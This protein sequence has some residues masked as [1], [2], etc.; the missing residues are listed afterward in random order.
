MRSGVVALV[1][2]PNSGK[3]TLF[4]WLTGSRFKTV[5]YPGA[6]VEYSLG[7]SQERFGDPVWVMDTPGTYSL[8]P[9][10]PDEE[11][12]RRAI[13]EHEAHGAAR[14][15]VSVVDATQLARHLF[16]TRQLMESGFHV[17]VAVTMSDLLAERGERLDIQRLESDLG[18]P[19]L[20]V[21]GR[22]GGGVPELLERVRQR[23]DQTAS[24]PAQPKPLAPWDETKIEEIFHL[25]SQLGRAVT[26]PLTTSGAD[27]SA[28]RSDQ[29]APGAAARVR[30]VTQLWT[31]RLDRF[32]LHPVFG[33]VFFFLI[34]GTLFSG[35]FWAAAPLMDAVDQAF[36]FVGESILA[37]S[38][39]SLWAQLLSNG[40]I[41][42]LA[43]VLVFVPQIF[44]LFVGIA[45]LEDSGYLARSATLIDKPLSLLGLGGRSFVPLLS[46][47]ACA[48]PA[49]MAARTINSPR[50][51]WLTLFIIPLMSCSAR[52]PVYALLLAFVFHGESAWKGGVALAAIYLASLFVGAIAAVLVGRFVKTK[53]R[54]FFMLE[55][56]VYRQ[57][58]F[59]HVLRQAWTR[60]SNYV[61]RAGPPIFAFA[62][63]IWLA[64]T[65]PNYKMEDPTERL[66]TSFAGQVAK[67]IEPLFE[68]MGG[69]WRTGIGLISAFAAREVFVSSLAIVFQ[70]AEGEDDAT[71]QDTLLTKMREAKAPNGYPLF[72]LASVLGLIVFFMIALQCLSTVIVAAREFGGWRTAIVQLVVYNIVAYVLVVV[73]VQGLR[74]I[75]IA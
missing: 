30:G 25:N 68:P 53:D 67:P 8:N 2:S 55:L 12:T 43:A 29:K 63:L 57:P 75:G 35:I 48:V 4:N 10:S 19:V 24:Q 6:T 27:G 46:G 56:P 70:I 9:K 18:V 74:A 21:D 49:M 72:T 65:F 41:A 64:T 73:L 11:V 50:E 1:G 59:T 61:K 36:S 32:L 14:L 66:N 62:L 42:S 23:L 28:S 31:E 7:H 71:M 34:M 3:T 20:A 39:E 45:F 5:N 69:D 51:R 40:V 16:L 37:T 47:Y 44:I 26:G 22:L 60:T 17:I 54:S 38:P 52:L 33:L 15:V 13:F 58:H